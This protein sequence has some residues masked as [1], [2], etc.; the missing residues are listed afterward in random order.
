MK[1][2]LEETFDVDN[3]IELNESTG[4][5]TYIIKGTFSTPDKKNRNGRI[6][7]SRIWEDNVSKYQNEIVNKT[8][9][10]LM[11]KEHPARTTVDPWS[12][13]AQIRKLEM[14]NG[15]VYG[16]AVLLNIP[17]TQVMRE[18]IDKGIKIGVSSRGVGKM[19]GHIVEEYNLITY[20]IVSTPSDYNA[21]LEGFNESM[22][23]E[24]VDITS[25][26]KGGWI[27]TP[28]GCALAESSK[29]AWDIKSKSWI[30]ASK[31]YIEA[32]EDIIDELKTIK[33][34]MDAVTVIN[35][36][37]ENR[38][39]DIVNGKK[40][41]IASTDDSILESTERGS[42]KCNCKAKS[43]MDILNSISNQKESQERE[44]EEKSL[45]E[46]FEKVFGDIKETYKRPENFN[47]R[48]DDAENWDPK[49][50]KEFYWAVE[51]IVQD[52]PSGK[53]D[54]LVSKFGSKMLDYWKKNKKSLDKEIKNII[55]Q[56]H[57]SLKED[58]NV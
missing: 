13:V 2:I 27:C 3:E 7:A 35:N 10:T 44:L 36:G 54:T 25:N 51:T 43:L 1:L 29:P 47:S 49:D 18:L 40:M 32:Q 56:Y 39:F 34:K 21:N 41:L 9:N 19:N 15:L 57:G 16:E 22:I 52:I 8:V 26:G 46:S 31:G 55:K 37:L 23:L 45:V 58:N 17:E 6:Y 42:S 12:A 48:K 38:D 14:R 33:N 53:Y 30:N 20:D 50:D 24:G 5:K 4:Q 28:E 11:E